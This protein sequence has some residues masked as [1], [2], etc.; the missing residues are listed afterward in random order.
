[1]ST[2]IGSIPATAGLYT[3]TPSTLTP[4]AVNFTA[5]AQPQVLYSGGF[6]FSLPSSPFYGLYAYDQGQEA[7]TAS[8]FTWPNQIFPF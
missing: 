5:V 2:G 1:L 6:D 3:L 8:D 7:T 4:G